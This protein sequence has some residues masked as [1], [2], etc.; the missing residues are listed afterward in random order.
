M[1][2][3]RR[4]SPPPPPPSSSFSLDRLYVSLST[5]PLTNGIHGEGYQRNLA[6]YIPWIFRYCLLL[7][8]LLIIIIFFFF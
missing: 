7:L 6:E 4:H 8:F 1:A 2:L 3:E 5:P